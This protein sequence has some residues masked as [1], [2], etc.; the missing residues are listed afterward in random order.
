MNRNVFISHS[1]KFFPLTEYFA[2]FLKS[3]GLT[4]IVVERF[5]SAG[6]LWPPAEKVD[7]CERM[8]DS[9]IIIATPDE[10][11]DD[12]SVPRM[13]VVYE[14]GRLKHANKK[15]IVLKEKTTTLPRSLDPVYIPFDMKDPSDCLDRLDAELESIFGEGVIV[16]KP[17]ST[18]LAGPR[19]HPAYTLNS[20]GLVPENPETI[21]TEVRRIFM[22]KTKEE[23]RQIVEDIIGHL[24]DQ[25][26]ETRRVAG[27]VLEEIMQYDPSLVPIDA[28]IKM[29]R[30][31][32][33]SVRSSASVCL[34][35]LAGIAPSQAPL[36]I[37]LRLASPQEDWYVFTPAIAALKTLAHRMPRALDAIIQMARSSNNNEASL[38]IGALCDV[39]RNDPEILD[40]S[41]LSQLERNPSKPV[42]D[43][44]G[45]IKTLL[46][47]KEHGPNVIRYSPY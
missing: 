11:Q 1:N 18:Q 2:D 33:F 36:D 30:D 47:R 31:E 38:G 20:K 45:E 15:T 32:N 43:A 6:R 34:F 8:C 25:N 7:Y 5:T 41:R 42:Q 23:Q 22:E 19:T 46:K 16:K 14:L 21:Q 9:A 40:E 44:V 10:I 3:R 39:I 17:F 4:P 12:A 28:I 27:F 24:G 29:S 26:Q 37:V 13:D 35:I